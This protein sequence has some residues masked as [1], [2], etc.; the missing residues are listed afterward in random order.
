MEISG[1]NWIIR[2]NKIMHHWLFNQPYFFSR[3]LNSWQPHPK[4]EKFCRHIE[5]PKHKIHILKNI[6]KMK[7][8]QP[9]Y[10]IFLSSF[11]EDNKVLWLLSTSNRSMQ[12]FQEVIKFY[13]SAVTDLDKVHTNQN[14]QLQFVDHQEFGS[15]LVWSAAFDQLMV[16]NNEYW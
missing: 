7:V 6:K 14:F 13:L 8:V 11:T 15:T 12:I 5:I 9:T 3:S 2:P 4:Y 1:F 10:A 16:W